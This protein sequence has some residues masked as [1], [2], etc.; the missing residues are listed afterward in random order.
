MP[1]RRLPLIS[2]CY[3][4]I[5]SRGVNKIPIFQERRDYQRFLNL[6]NYCCYSDYPIRFSQFIFLSN[7]QKEKVR[8]NLKK[9]FVDFVCYCLMPNHFH[10]LLK[11]K[12][13][14]G[15]SKF[16]NRLL[17]SYSKFFNLKSKRSGPLFEQ[18][19]KAVLV[20]EDEQL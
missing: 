19:F 17:N 3:Y 18:R 20:D 16:I 8:S 14:D 11:Q 7:Q 12:T 15:I 1:G 13:D 10:F 2:G 4:H 5:F 6:M 9:K